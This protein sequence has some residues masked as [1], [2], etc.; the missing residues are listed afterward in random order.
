MKLGAFTSCLHDRDLDEVIDVARD[1]GLTSL[2]LNVGGFFDAFHLHPEVLLVS[3]H[4]RDVLAETLS[5]GG[6][7]ITAL[8]CSGNPLHPDREV[9]PQH[10]RDLHRAI[11]LASLIDVPVVVAQSG[12]PGAEAGASLPSWV[13]SPWDSAYSDVLD[14]QWSL[15]EK[16]W[17][18]AGKLAE[19]HGV[20]VAVEMHPH[21]LVYNP[22]T[23]ERLI[24]TAGSE[25]IGCE[26]DPS[27]LFWQG[28]DPIG[29]IERFGDRVFLA[30]A[31]DTVI[32]EGNLRRNGFLNNLWRRNDGPNRLG[33]GGRYSVNDCPED[34]SYEFVAIGR[35]HDDEFWGAWLA[36]L[37]AVNPN[38]AVNIEHEDV[39]LGG[40]EG[41]AVAADCLR[42]SAALSG[43]EFDRVVTK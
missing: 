18:E 11:R 5:V 13:V 26:M 19:A 10:G 41:L 6:V 25:A 36:A 3:Q 16:Y 14:Y 8:N 2:E 30:A 9:G 24:E 39:G 31:K 17:V 27:H 37:A 20:R 4:S 29:A 7:E 28:I 32:H 15:A 42:R 38:M 23:L 22:P 34:A 33:I 43:V 35:G 12:N 21:Q 40:I 1:V